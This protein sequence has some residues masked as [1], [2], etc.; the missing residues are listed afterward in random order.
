MVLL[1]KRPEST[2]WLTVTPTIRS[3]TER[4]TFRSHSPVSGAPTTAPVTART[5]APAHWTH[6]HHLTNS[7]NHHNTCQHST[8]HTHQ[9]YHLLSLPYQSTTQNLSPI[10]TLLIQFIYKYRS[11]SIDL[12]WKNPH[13]K[14]FCFQQHHHH[15]HHHLIPPR[16]LNCF[17]DR[18]DNKFQCIIQTSI[19][20]QIWEPNKQLFNQRLWIEP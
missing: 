15:H 14:F 1:E 9:H 10:P 7:T 2:A 11:G 17:F 6:S 3:I 12:I 8:T 16:D 18:V 19:H 5:P 20:N 13:T 4:R